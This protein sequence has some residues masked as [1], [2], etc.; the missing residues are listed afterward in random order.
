MIGQV[1]WLETHDSPDA[2]W[3]VQDFAVRPRRGAI[4]GVPTL[5]SELYRR[6]LTYCRWFGQ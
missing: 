3:P 1:F 4:D 2:G 6:H 5:P